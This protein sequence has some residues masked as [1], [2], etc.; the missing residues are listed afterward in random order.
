[1]PNGY[2]FTVVISKLHTIKDSR[3]YKMLTPIA[4]QAGLESN[5]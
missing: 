1:M 3:K 4:P 2:D 5:F